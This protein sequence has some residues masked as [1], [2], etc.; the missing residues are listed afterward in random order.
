[1]FINRLFGEGPHHRCL[2][3][4]F[5]TSTEVDFRDVVYLIFLLFLSS[6][7]CSLL[8]PCQI[9]A[10]MASSDFLAFLSAL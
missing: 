5:I 4:S 6:S 7:Y 8:A 3:V 9:E 1:M 10:V 2:L